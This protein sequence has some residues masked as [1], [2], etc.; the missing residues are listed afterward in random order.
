M[1]LKFAISI[2]YLLW[3][4][5]GLQGKWAEGGV[6]QP[7]WNKKVIPESSLTA[8]LLKKIAD[9]KI[10][11]EI[12]YNGNNCHSLVHK[13][14][15]TLLLLGTYPL[16]SWNLRQAVYTNSKYSHNFWYKLHENSYIFSWN[17]QN[18]GMNMAVGTKLIFTEQWMKNCSNNAIICALWKDT[19]QHLGINLLNILLNITTKQI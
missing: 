3:S 14:I 13:K 12:L 16:C 4:G 8:F 6:E 7:L 2:R 1:W 15:H 9:V 18:T 11:W 19:S 17:K 10:K 5:T